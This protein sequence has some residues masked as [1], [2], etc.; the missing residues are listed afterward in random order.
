MSAAVLSVVTKVW[1]YGVSMMNYLKELG[2]Q[3]ILRETNQGKL[4]QKDLE[5]KWPAFL[6]KAECPTSR[7]ETPDPYPLGMLNVGHQADLLS[8]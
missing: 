8:A 2:T 3:D 5:G 4:R 6:T 7:G 1:R